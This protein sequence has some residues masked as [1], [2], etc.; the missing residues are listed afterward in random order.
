MFRLLERR[1]N[2][3]S[4][5]LDDLIHGAVWLGCHVRNDISALKFLDSFPE[6]MDQMDKDVVVIRR[7]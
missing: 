7:S 6:L 1:G 3:V 4:D 2:P 5:I